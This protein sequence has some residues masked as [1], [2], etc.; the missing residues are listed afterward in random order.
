MCCNP[1]SRRRGHFDR[2]RWV[3]KLFNYKRFSVHPSVITWVL[4]D[5]SSA[6]GLCDGR[7]VDIWALGV[8]LSSK[9]VNIAKPRPTPYGLES[10]LS[11][12]FFECRGHW[13]IRLINYVF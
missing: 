10:T 7:L 6:P 1:A 12:R 11:C 8:V 5:C 13:V 3:R 4:L 2:R 9:P